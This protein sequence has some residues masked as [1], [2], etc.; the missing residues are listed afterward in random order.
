MNN[1]NI[2]NVF[3]LS[4]LLLF[5]LK[6]SKITLCL[7]AFYIVFKLLQNKDEDNFYEGLFLVP[8]IRIMDSLGSS[9][10]V[11]ILL[12]IPLFVYLFRRQF[13]VYYFPFNYFAFLFIWEI[14][15]IFM[16]QSFDNLFS[17]IST[18]S[19]MLF[20]VAISL[21]PHTQIDSRRAWIT[22]TIGIFFSAIAALLVNP[23]YSQNV[24][25]QVIIGHRFTGYAGE[26]NYY[27][28]YICIAL[29]AIFTFQNY[30]RTDY[31]TMI[32][33]IILG[34][35]TAS[36]MCFIIMALT[37]MFGFFSS[38]RQYSVKSK[39]DFV[40]YGVF[41]IGV[42]YVVFNKQFGM[43]VNNL[44]RRAKLGN[45]GNS[46]NFDN[47]S[48]GRFSIFLGYMNALLDDFFALLFG[49][50]TSYRMY[51][52]VGGAVAH[53]TYLDVILSWGVLG[54]YVLLKYILK[55]SKIYAQKVGGNTGMTLPIMVVLLNFCDLSC[56]SST[57][58][59]WIVA[60]V[61]VISFAP[62]EYVLPY[63]DKDKWAI[64]I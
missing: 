8:N 18:F 29:S 17:E 57:M 46:V 55:W 49:K 20:C 36:K 47:I 41:I 38:I 24:V 14:S 35:L 51:F 56:L 53:N 45:S 10:I 50:G 19:G 31:V 27:A 58:F 21:D 34:C 2:R 26:P 59:W 44:L 30:T 33:L 12:A 1:I 60:L 25:D 5:G 4:F 15:H 6:F 16:F 13:K 37:L 22:F 48:S 54:G 9:Y 39:R 63:H 40:L 62:K 43:F 52:N 7:T 32:F 61:I 64:T 11:N 42:C 3:F 28:L 23:V